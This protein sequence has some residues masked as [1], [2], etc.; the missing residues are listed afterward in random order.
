MSRRWIRRKYER[1]EFLCPLNSQTTTS[2]QLESSIRSG[3]IRR[4]FQILSHLNGNPT[5][6][7][8]FKFNGSQRC[9]ALQLAASTSNVAITQLILWCSGNINGLDGQAQNALAY[10]KTKEMREF[11]KSQGCAENKSPAS[12]GRSPNSSMMNK[13]YQSYQNNP[14]TNF[15]FRDNKGISQMSN[16]VTSDFDQLPTSII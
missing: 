2:D 13:S 5:P 1:K 8:E 9:T 15:T 12:L 10:A 16:L 6:L 11:L 4:V 7:N 3:D 14:A